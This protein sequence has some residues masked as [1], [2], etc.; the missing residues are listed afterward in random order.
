MFSHQE[1]DVQISA[2]EVAQHGLGGH[3]GPVSSVWGAGWEWSPVGADTQ[4]CPDLGVWRGSHTLVGLP[5]GPISVPL[6]CPEPK[7]T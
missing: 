4:S 2:S 6:D 5:P 7:G 3:L 1:V